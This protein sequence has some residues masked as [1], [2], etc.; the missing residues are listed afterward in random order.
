MSK[1]ISQREYKRLITK[2]KQGWAC[3]YRAEQ[4]N[5]ELH[6]DYLYQVKKLEQLI[7]ERDA[8]LYEKAHIPEFV[9]TEITEMIKQLKK[10]VE[11]PICYEEL[12]ADKIKFSNCGHKYCETCL[13]KIK[14]CA[15]CRKKIYH[16]D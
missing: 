14:E 9:K 4:L 7:Q 13:S 6:M 12:P 2:S 15:I 5:H 3:F 16:K 8:P 10:S 1:T 11:C